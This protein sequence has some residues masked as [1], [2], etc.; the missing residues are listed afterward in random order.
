MKPFKEN[1][2]KLKKALMTA[3]HAK[4]KADVN[5]GWQMKVMNRIRGLGPLSGQTDSFAFFGQTVWR[6]APAACV[7]II[8]LTFFLV[9]SDFI[10]EYELINALTSNPAEFT[11]EQLFP[12]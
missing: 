4:E 6:F 5:E 11:I 2:D 7:L 3:Y 1:N 8:A 12:V 10:P 9:K